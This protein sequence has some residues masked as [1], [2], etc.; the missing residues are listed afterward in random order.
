MEAKHGS[1]PYKA[2]GPDGIANI[3][4]QRCPLLIDYLLP[5][6][7]PAINLRTYYDPWRESI[8]VILRKPGKPDYSTPKAYQPIALLNTT[9]KLLSAIVT[10]RTS[11]ILKS[12]NLLPNTHFGGRPGRSME[13]SLHLLEN[14][15]RHAWRQ[16]QVISALFLDIEGAFPNAVTDRLIHNMK[17]HRLPPEIISFISRMLHGR[18]MK[19]RFDDYTSE[20]FNI[21]NGIGQGDQLSMILYI[22]YDSDL[23]RTAAGKHELTL[24]FVDNT[25]FL[26]IGKTFQETHQILCDMLERSGG[27]FEWSTLH[28]SRFAPSKFA[29]IDF[30]MN[31]SKERPPL[32]VK[33][34]TI[35]PSPTHKFLGVIL[36]QELRWR[37]HASYATTKG[38]RYT[39]LLRQLSKTAQGVPTKLIHQLYQ[40]VVIPRTLYAA[41]V[42]LRPTYNTE[43]DEAIRGSNGTTK[44]V[45]QTQRTVMLAITGA[46]RSSP[47]DSLEIHANLLPGPLVIQRILHNSF[48]RISTLPNHHPLNSIVTR[49]AKRGTVKRHKS[50]LH[51][52]AQNLAVDPS[53]TELIHPRPIHPDSHTPF[54]T[55]IAASKKEAIAEFH[56]CNNRT[57]I[58]T[59]GSCTNGKVGAA[60]S[61]YVNFNH[62]ATLRYH[63]GNETEHMVFEAEAV[64]LILAAHLLLIRNEVT[65]PPTIFADNQAVIRSGA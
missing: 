17:R 27:G 18:K 14:T 45:E 61:L 25:A 50:A 65:F 22:I 37:K 6:F 46:M 39:M 24:A 16:G 47:T 52:L 63:L 12:H 43:T 23:V 41:S 64:G 62:V 40:M 30:T 55:S 26:P 51:C 5:L 1:P 9:M 56:R 34:V 53:R 59:D 21:T 38:A 28:N 57:M 31:R 58:F 3:V 2:P 4:F 54:T 20:W 44:K 13:D 49:I 42:W 48:L 33:G 19:L 35:T 10:D 11:F 60:A 15:I 7:N 29:L 8:T 32:V 36:D